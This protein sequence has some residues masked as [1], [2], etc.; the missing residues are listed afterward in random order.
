MLN[1]E[2]Y[3]ELLSDICKIMMK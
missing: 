3:Y 1:T 2:S